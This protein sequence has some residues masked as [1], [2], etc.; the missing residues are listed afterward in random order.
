MDQYHIKPIK[1]TLVLLLLPHGFKM[2][3]SL[4][5]GNEVQCFSF[6][7]LFDHQNLFDTSAWT[8]DFPNDQC[9]FQPA[10]AN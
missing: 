10:L 3:I 2:M 8:C 6:T 9:I 7:V 4:S 5:I 1:F